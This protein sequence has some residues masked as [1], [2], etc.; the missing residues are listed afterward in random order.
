MLV[1]EEIN[2]I[3]YC[4]KLSGAEFVRSV[5]VEHIERSL[6]FYICIIKAYFKSVALLG[7]NF[8]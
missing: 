7:N 6:N 4:F 8:Y 2:N 1:F 5:T 3:L